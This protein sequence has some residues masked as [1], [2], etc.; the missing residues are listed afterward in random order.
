MVER[1]RWF[2]RRFPL[3]LPVEA[4][5][6]VLERVRGTPARL[7]ERVR[8]VPHEVLVQQPDD[9]WSIQENVGHLLDLEPLWA[10]RLDD[11]LALAP[12]LR[13]AD[14]QNRKTHEARHNENSLTE[15]LGAFRVAR[16]ATVERLEGL[17]GEALRLTALHPRL[18]EPMTVVDLSYFVAEHDDHHLARITELLRTL[19]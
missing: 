3:G 8:G 11:F 5:P 12:E 15:L 6:D 16:M 14:L 9:E 17:S 18:Q 4:F 13:P 19:E 2:D 10:G 7:E 1:R